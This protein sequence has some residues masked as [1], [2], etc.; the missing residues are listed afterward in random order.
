MFNTRQN[1]EYVE[2]KTCKKKYDIPKVLTQFFKYINF[3][4]QHVFFCLVRYLYYD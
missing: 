4:V 3:V 1:R 2:Y